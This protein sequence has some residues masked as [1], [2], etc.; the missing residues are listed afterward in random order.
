MEGRKEHPYFMWENIL[1][2]AEAEAALENCF[3]EIDKVAVQLRKKELVYFTGCGTSHNLAMSFAQYFNKVG[4]KCAV[5]VPAYE[6]AHH[7]N[8][9][10][11]KS[12]AVVGI[13]HSGGTAPL[14]EA[15]RKLASADVSTFAFTN[16]KD[17]KIVQECDEC[18]IM[19]GWEEV[20]PKTRSYTLG[21]AAALV[22]A[23]SVAEKKEAHAG[24]LSQISEQIR[25][26]S[27]YWAKKT[28]EIAEKIQGRQIYIVGAGLNHGVAMEGALKMMETAQLPAI[29]FELEEIGHGPL[30]TAVNDNS[31]VVVLQSLTDGERAKD[32]INAAKT[33]GALA[34]EVGGE[35]GEY[36]IKTPCNNEILM[37]IYNSI[38][39]QMLAY[40]SALHRGLYPDVIST[41]TD[42]HAKAF[43]IIFG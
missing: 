31:V 28:K 23:L 4:A 11:G 35:D 41:R 16:T 38:V 15:M 6:L 3:D 26:K 37:P 18:L 7:M 17:S 20:E 40:W 33:M 36:K 13:S 34:V 43:E 29:G 9:A 25:Q 8:V 2:A 42:R 24:Y 27:E 1:S 19:P 39:L 32:I 14:V 30:E 21:L 5:V 12:A 10:N 22:L